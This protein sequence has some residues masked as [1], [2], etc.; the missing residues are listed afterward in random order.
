MAV[1]GEDLGLGLV[2]LWGLYLWRGGKQGWRVVK[3]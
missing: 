3:G 2:D 1:Q